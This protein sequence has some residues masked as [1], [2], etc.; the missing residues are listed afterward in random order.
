[1]VGR[2]FCTCCGAHRHSIQHTDFP[3]CGRCF[4]GKCRKCARGIRVMIWRQHP[5][6]VNL[7]GRSPGPRMACGWQCG[8]SVT[9]SEM[10]SHFTDCPSRPTAYATN[11]P[12][13][14]K[15]DRGGRPAGARMPCGW[16]CGAHLTATEMRAHFARCRRRPKISG[17][18]AVLLT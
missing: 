18:V 4:Q 8:A 16:M 2:A 11:S 17:F 6:L 3:Y 10:R 13:P 14:T 12:S 15:N 1:M 5:E 7:I 9:A